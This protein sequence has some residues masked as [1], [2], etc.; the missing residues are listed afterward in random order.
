MFNCNNSEH[1][2][3]KILMKADPRMGKTTLGRKVARDWAKGVFKM[4][5]IIFFLPLKFV[6]PGDSIENVIMQ[7]NPELEGL[8]ISQ[9][10]LKALLNRFSS[11]ILIILDGLDEHRMGQNRDVLSIIKNQMMLDCGIVVSSRPHSVK[12]VEQYFPTI[13]RVGGFTETEARKFVSNFFTDR[14]KV[15]QILQFKPSDSRENFPVHKCPILLSFLCLL[16]KEEEIDLSDKTLTIGDLYLRMVQCL[17]RKFTIRKGIQFKGGE[18]VQVMKSVGILALKTLLLKDP[19]LQKSE[20]LEVVGDFAFEY[21]FFAGHEDFRLCSDPIADI[22]VTY[23]HRSLEEFFESFGFLQALDSG[24]S[25][26]DILSSDC[27]KPIFMVNPLVLQFCLW[28]LTTTEFFSSWRIVYD[29]LVAY[30]AHQIDTHVLDIG[31]VDEI[32]PAMVSE[33]HCSM[34]IRL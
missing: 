2:N 34:R 5:S 7:Q 25:V 32:F 1:K 16:V 4:F 6:R 27:E 3:R 10:K 18:F 28:F 30:V 33:K 9:Q 21:G 14:K 19:L 20:V 29:K 8:G 17:Y 24:Q 23:P 22:C 26:D 12:E 15:S 13:I 11:K 31:V